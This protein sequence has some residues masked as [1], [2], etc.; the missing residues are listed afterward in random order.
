MGGEFLILARGLITIAVI[1]PISALILMFSTKIFK[2]TDQSYRTAF[3]I[4]AIT[5]IVGFI[6]DSI[7]RFLIPKNLFE[8]FDWLVLFI[9]LALSVTLIKKFYESEWNKVIPV[10]LVWLLIDMV[11]STVLG[12]VLA[13]IFVL[14]GLGG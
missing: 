4:A 12:F 5:D 11:V 2:F 9:P 1:I 6:L 3:Y 10:F 14:V 7:N 13:I 8:V